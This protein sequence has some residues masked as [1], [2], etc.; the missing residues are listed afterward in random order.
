MAHLFALPPYPTAFWVTAVFVV[1]LTGLGKSGFGSGIGALA[2]P[3]LALTIGVADAAA[4]LLPL[5]IIMDLFTIPYYRKRFDRHH[6]LILLVGSLFGI[7]IGA[8]FFETLSHNDQALKRGIGALAV[9]FVI[10]QVGR[11]LILG[12]MSEN[13]PGR[14][15]GWLMGALGGFTSTI[16]HAGGPPVTI[17]LVPQQ[18]PRDIYVGTAA[19]LFAA[20]NLIKLVPYYYL[21]LL[22]IGNLSTVL[23]LAPLAYVGVWLG[24][25]LNRRFTDKWFTRF[26]Y[27]FLL[28]TGLQLLTGWNLVT[29]FTFR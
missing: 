21:G 7:A 4:L 8:Y 25:F 17:Y 5:L 2:T 14:W 6:L 10:L 9:L 24:V 18:L 20:I 16:A 22:R 29:L 28:L 1:V 23:V 15:V 3:L 26:V 12:A 19:L 27:T 13:R 11:S